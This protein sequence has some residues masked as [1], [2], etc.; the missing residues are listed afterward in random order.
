MAW[1]SYDYT[2]RVAVTGSVAFWYRPLLDIDVS[3]GRQTRRVKALVDSGTE[4]TIMDAEL[5]GVLGIESAGR[6]TAIIRAFASAK[7]AFL[8][9]VSVAVPGFNEILRTTILV[10]PDSEFDVILGQDDFFRRFLVKFEKSKNKFYL[11]VAN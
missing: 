7:E 2:P 8:A 3:H 10:A 5:A 9:P 6:Q 4:L 11:D 1:R